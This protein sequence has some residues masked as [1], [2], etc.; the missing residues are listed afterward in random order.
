MIDE[1]KAFITLCI[2]ESCVK[3]D[4]LQAYWYTQKSTQTPLFP[5]V[6]SFK[7]YKLQCKFLHFI[8]SAELDVSDRL[9]KVR[10]PTDYFNNKFQTLYT[11]KQDTA[12]DGSLMKLHGRLSF[13][14]FNPNKRAHFGI[15]YYKIYEPSSDYCTQFRIYNG[16][17]V[18]DQRLPA[19]E[20]I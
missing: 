9:V 10:C 13:I 7:Q 18:E 17:K 1:L 4:T 2:I 14:H 6:M 16:Q 11:P 20:A 12:T 19:H 5:S 8:D 15:K 3:K